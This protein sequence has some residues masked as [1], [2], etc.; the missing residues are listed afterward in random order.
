MELGTSRSKGG[1]P[2]PPSLPQAPAR[3]AASPSSP[4]ATSAPARARHLLWSELE[5]RAR[6]RPWC[7]AS[8]LPLPA[9]PS[10]L[11]SPAIPTA[12]SSAN[13]HRI[14][15]PVLHPA[16]S[17][18]APHSMKQRAGSM[19]FSLHGRIPLRWTP[20]RKPTTLPTLSFLLQRRPPLRCSAP[21]TPFSHGAAA[22]PHGRPSVADQRPCPYLQPLLAVLRGACRLFDE[23][24][25]CCRRAPCLSPRDC[26]LD[27]V[28]KPSLLRL[29]PSTFLGRSI[30]CLTEQL[31]LSSPF[32]MSST[33]VRHP[34]ALAIIIFLC[35]V[36]L[37]NCCV[38]LIAASRQCH[39]S[40]TRVR[41]KTGRVNHMHAQLKSDPIQ[42][43]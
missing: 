37:L 10:A 31:V 26:S 17:A 7:G 42:V 22:N 28:V 40:R 13:S 39:S 36:K 11:R 32:A 24:S 2:W 19:V 6:R 9:P 27:V 33:P 8:A 38:C 1:I 43:D 23:M 14:Q 12:R 35:S 16:S 3:R 15:L 30:K 20:R 21:T 4:N 18:R 41:C 25:S 29:T 5:Q 34:A